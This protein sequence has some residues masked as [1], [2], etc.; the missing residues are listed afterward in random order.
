MFLFLCDVKM[1]VVLFNENWSNIPQLCCD[2]D[3]YF[4]IRMRI[5]DIV[6][7]FEWKK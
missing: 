3:F 7:A 6:F 1:G 4:S 5:V 2:W